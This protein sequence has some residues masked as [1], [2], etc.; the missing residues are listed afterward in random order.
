[1]KTGI[2]CMLILLTIYT[3][4]AQTGISKKYKI[5][6]VV[7]DSNII[8]PPSWAFGILYGGY[9]SQEQTLER[10]S[11]IQ[12]HNYPIDAYWIDSWF[13]SFAEKGKGPKHYLDF[14]GDTLSY[15]DRKAM[16][17]ELERHGIKGGFWV[18]D[19]ILETGNEQVFREFSDSGY[20]S[21]IYLNKDPWHNSGTGTA[22]FEK[23]REHPGTRC[24][25]I[26]FTNPKAVAFF[27]KRMKPFFDEGADFIKLD[28]TAAIPAV[29]TMFEMSQELGKETKGRGF[30]LSHSFGT[31]DESYK[32]YPAKWTD[33]TRSDW[34]IET[35]LIQFNSWVPRIALKENIRMFTDPALPCSRIPFLTNDMGGFDMGHTVQPEEELF[36]RWLQFSVFNPL[37]EVFSQPENP[38]SNLAWLYSKRADSLFRQYTHLRLQLFPYIYSYAHQSRIEGKNMIRSLPPHYYQYLF[39]NEMLVAPVYEKKKYTRDVQLPAGNW[40]NSWTG[41]N[42]KGNQSVSVPAP[43][44]QIPL[45]VRAGSLIPARPYAPSVEQG[46]NDSLSLHI[47][48]GDDGR[49]ILYEDDGISNDYLQGGLA[50]TLLTYREGRVK[51]RFKIHAVKG[52]YRGM[53]DKRYW[54]VILHAKTI[55]ADKPLLSEEGSSVVF[56]GEAPVT[57]P[58]TIRFRLIQQ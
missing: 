44:E 21:S 19:C 31:E 37:T 10:V 29:K 43:T 9:T 18:W 34:N 8:L 48:Q 2:T 46:S 7:K 6:Q 27:K 22:M 24:G 17:D 16:W 56:S 36:I 49:F 41:E 39:G 30:L 32:R 26:D 15:P 12:Q 42:Y 50:K 51:G 25:N 3:A 20:F 53:K 23:N 11:M 5:R 58:L 35:P 33:D 47:F 55:K 4:S 40:I 52:N 45:F 54:R 13:W 1:M 28:R 57:K 14:S 38:T